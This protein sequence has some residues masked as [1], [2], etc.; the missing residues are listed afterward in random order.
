MELISF[1]HTAVDAAAGGFF[2][3]SKNAHTF[4]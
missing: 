4:V 2:A 3:L 1:W